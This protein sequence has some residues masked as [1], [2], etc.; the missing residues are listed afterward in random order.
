[1]A[2][3]LS[4]QYRPGDRVEIFLEAAEGDPQ[5]TPAVVYRLQHPGVWVVDDDRR[6]WFVTNTR[7]IRRGGDHDLAAGGP[8]PPTAG[9]G[10]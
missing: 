2:E 5:W 1:V 3:R 9:S 7:R 4:E 10:A 6:M 8:A